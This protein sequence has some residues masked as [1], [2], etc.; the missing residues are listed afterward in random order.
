[1]VNLFSLLLLFGIA[2]TTAVAIVESATTSV[3]TTLDEKE[4]RP[5]G[6]CRSTRASHLRILVVRIQ[7]Q[8]RLVCHNHHDGILV[9]FDRWVMLVERCRLQ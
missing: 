2:G 8:L 5:D 9:D 1:M 7:R 6:S 4:R 3:T